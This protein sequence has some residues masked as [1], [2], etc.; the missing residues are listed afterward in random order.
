MIDV[1]SCGYIPRNAR[2][3]KGKV[4]QR[5]KRIEWEHLIPVPFIFSKYGQEKSPNLYVLDS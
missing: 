5:A 1:K 3:K 4:N 2:T